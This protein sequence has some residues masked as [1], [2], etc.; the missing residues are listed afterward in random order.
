MEKAPGIEVSQV[1]PQLSE[2]QRLALI[3]EIVRIQ[4]EA[5]EHR[6]PCYG[7]IFFF[8]DIGPEMVSVIDETFAIRPTMDRSFWSNEREDMDIDRGPCEYMLL[9]LHSPFLTLV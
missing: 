5:L 8:Q 1:W 7:S 4:K 6:L 9:M 3:A 2:E